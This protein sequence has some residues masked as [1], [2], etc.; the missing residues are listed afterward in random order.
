MVKN[1]RYDSSWDKFEEAVKTIQELLKSN[2]A[3]WL[4]GCLKEFSLAI[5][6]EK[7]DKIDDISEI[8]RDEVLFL[9]Y[10]YINE[11]EPNIDEMRESLSS[12]GESEISDV[13][14]EK[15]LKSVYNKYELVKDAFDTDKLKLR[16]RL[17]N[18]SISPKLSDFKYNIM[19]QNLPNGDNARC[20]LINIACKKKLEGFY[21]RGLASKIEELEPETDITFI[22]DEDD[23]NLLISQ[24]EEMKQKIKESYNGSNTEGNK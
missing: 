13:E 15:L 1:F 16:Y 12:N 7:S 6:E 2:N 22:C 21:S 24:F 19:I 18:N 5:A 14:I 20:A 8:I 23:I 10:L 4:I 3:H 9:L 11:K 17:K